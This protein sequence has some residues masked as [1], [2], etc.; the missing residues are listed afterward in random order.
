MENNI[1]V[2]LCL[3][4]MFD[5]KTDSSSL[6]INGYNYIKQ[7]ILDK[8]DTDVYIHNWDVDKS[9]MIKQ[10]YNPINCVFEE[11]IDFENF[12]VD[13]G[14]NLI[15]SPPRNP[16]TVLSH[17]YSIQKSFELLYESEYSK[18]DFVIKS[19]F[20]LGQINRRTSPY[21]VECINFNKNN[22]TDRINM[23]WWPD[24][25]M[26]REGPP[27]MWFYSGYDTMNPF[28]NI[29]DTISDYMKY[30]S[31]F[32]NNIN[33]TLGSKHIS[34]AS[35][36]YKGFFEDNNLWSNRNALICEKN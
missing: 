29:F 35:V 30:N 33:H 28:V 22:P 9:D 23:A 8:F 19:R 24:K 11:Q 3:H 13:N 4:G 10:M 12:V 1:K 15:Q 2:A 16:K 31:D 5:S 34:N 21:N 32:R 17:F 25:W 36:L 14:L 6:G 26:L 18:Y 7:H 20:D 27:D